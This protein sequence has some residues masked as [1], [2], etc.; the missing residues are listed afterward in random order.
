MAKPSAGPAQGSERESAPLHVSCHAMDLRYVSQ[1]LMVGHYENDPIAAAEALIDRD[2]VAGEL[3][4]RNHL[5]LYAGPRGTTTVVLMS[6]SDRE[7]HQGSCRGAVVIGLGKLGDLSSVALAEA[8]RV[9][10]L[11]YLLQILDRAEGTAQL[12]PGVELASLLIGQNSTNE[13]HIE[14]SLAALV[15]GVLA[16]NEQFSKAFPK[17]SLRVGRLQLLEVYLDTAIT[18]T[19]SLRVLEGKLN[20]QDRKRLT[21]E[22]ELQCG[23][24]W[25]HRLDA[26]QETGYWPRLIVTNAEANLSTGPSTTD[27]TAR[28][29]PPPAASE[30]RRPGVQLANQLSF[31]FLGE[32]ARAETLQQQRQSGLVEKLLEASIQNPTYSE[33]LS[34][35]L[36]QLLVPSAFKEL[37]RGLEQLVMVL[38]DTTT[39]LPWELLLA[40]SKPLALSMAMV[41]QLQAPRFRPRV[42]QATSRSAYV[43]GNPS[44]AGFFN[45]FVGEGPKGSTGLASL[46]G[47]RMEAEKVLTLLGGSY[48]CQCS[49]EEENGVDVINKLYQQPYRVL[50]IAGHGVYEHPTRQGDRRSGVVL[51]GGILITAAEIEAMEVVPDLVFL[52]CCHLGT[53]KREPVAFNRLAASVARQLIEMG[54][55]AVVACGWAVDDQAAL[56]F[57]EVFYTAMLNGR[58]FGEAV[59]LARKEAHAAVPASN[60]WGAYQA[61]GDPAYQLET[62]DTGPADGSGPSLEDLA[63]WAPVTCMELIDRLKQLEVRIGHGDSH[64]GAAESL[65]QELLALLDSVPPSWLGSA[66]VAVAVADVHAAFG[67]AHWEEACRH[68]LA[69]I[70][71]HQGSDGLPVRAM[72]Q[73]ANLDARLGER[74]NDEARVQKGIERLEALIQIASSATKEAAGE[75]AAGPPGEWQALLGS[76]YKRLAA[77]RAR[78]LSCSAHPGGKK[79]LDSV[80]EPLNASIE[81]YSLASDQGVSNQLNRLALEAVRG[82]SEPTNGEAIQ[83]A[84]TLV[85]ELRST[86]PRDHSFWS[87]VAVADA[88]LARGLLDRRLAA[89]DPSGDAA[90]KEIEEAYLDVFTNVRNTPLERESV[91]EHL[92]LLGDLVQARSQ[93]RSDPC[94]QGPG[95]AARLRAI[96]AALQRWEETMG[97]KRPGPPDSKGGEDDMES[98]S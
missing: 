25:R 71:S 96:G 21:I 77:L 68:Y 14:D 58:R 88:L 56:V 86:L 10:T 9:G 75:Q 28:S 76:A 45:V 20:R 79:G 42:R 62:S 43:I 64:D 85:E 34:R 11:R 70:R 18:A 80:M 52:N 41:R 8:V 82:L 67:G 66:E 53:V 98:L 23:T 83:Q 51:S 1:P 81:A 74:N 19:R 27:G 15:E 95:L 87:R 30:E 73:L 78:T 47:A 17:V 37:A 94:P 29:A 36:F 72:E 69:A 92:S 57:A 49:I 2:I 39:N 97:A 84:Q 32:R 40:D 55:R 13:I 5:G 91:H 90:A 6:R 24:G 12:Q 60:T 59:F 46:D 50:H 63:R 65:Q 89:E 4:I 7:L 35:T 61:Y 48:S 3:S 31:S 16:A 93:C 54:V 26:A 44:S 22:P 38:D 33:D